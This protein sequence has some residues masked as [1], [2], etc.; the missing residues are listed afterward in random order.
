[1]PSAQVQDRLV[2]AALQGLQDFES[3]QGP[4]G[5]PPRLCVVGIGCRDEVLV[6]VQG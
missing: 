2:K 1:M 6:R 3:I 4:Q 5:P